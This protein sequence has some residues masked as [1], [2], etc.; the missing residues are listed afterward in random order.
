MD[1]GQNPEA[2]GMWNMF[3]A[4]QDQTRGRVN[5]MLFY[6]SMDAGK[7]KFAG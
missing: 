7:Q 3:W 5:D 1:A 4:K 6:N 2:V